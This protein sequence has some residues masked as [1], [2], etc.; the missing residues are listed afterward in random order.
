MSSPS[1]T[2]MWYDL[3]YIDCRQSADHTDPF[4]C[5]FAQGGIRMYTTTH[6]ASCPPIHCQ[7]GGECEKTYLIEG[8]WTGEPSWHCLYGSNLVVETCTD[9]PGVQ[10]LDPTGN[11][12]LYAGVQWT[13]V[14]ENPLW[15][16]VA[17]ENPVP[18][19]APE[20][21]PA[22]TPEYPPVQDYPEFANGFQ[23]DSAAGE[24]IPWYNIQD[25]EARS[26][27]Y[28][29]LP[30]DADQENSATEVPD[31]APEPFALESPSPLPRQDQP[32]SQTPVSS[33][34]P[35]AGRPI[36]AYSEEASEW[37]WLQTDGYEWNE[38]HLQWV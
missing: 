30:V 1:E 19:P 13:P 32:A 2:S 37:V 3:S 8:G 31:Q 35:G 23:W 38:E 20:Y 17:P 28:D 16:P 24:W 22:P 36:F 25:P 11:A 27:A 26:A 9:G 6:D 29:T 14:P 15:Y 18:Q 34:C 33:Q 21:P 12:Q 10:S 5:P 4:Y 7:L